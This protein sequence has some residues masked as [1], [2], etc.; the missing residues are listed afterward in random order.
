MT[1]PI[2]YNIELRDEQMAVRVNQAPIRAGRHTETH[3]SE[4]P[5]T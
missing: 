5:D 2:L 4:G 3:K 1:A